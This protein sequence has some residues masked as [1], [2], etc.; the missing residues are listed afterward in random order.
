MLSRV[1]HPNVIR[2]YDAFLEDN[3]LNI[4]MEY[5]AGGTLHA[6]VR[7]GPRGQVRKPICRA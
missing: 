2:Y 3:K 1:N 5:A 7:K 4:V 6:L